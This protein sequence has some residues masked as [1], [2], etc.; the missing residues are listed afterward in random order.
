MSAKKTISIFTLA[1]VDVAAV[2][3][4]RNFPSMAVYGWQLVFWY[5]LGTIM[6]LVPVSLVAAELATGWPKEGGIYAWV[7]EAFGEKVGF[8]SIWSVFAQ[9]QVWYPT[10]L[11]FIAITFAYAVNPS[12]QNNKVY[13]LIM[14]LAI[15]WGAT[16]FNFLGSR[17]SAS[18]SSI[19]TIL[20]SIIPALLL[21]VLGLAFLASGQPSNLP[22]FS[23]Q[24]FIPTFNLQTLVFVSSIPL[25]FAGME[26]AGYQ[27]NNID[28]P[29]TKFPRSIFTAALVI[30]LASVFGT[31]PI[32]MAVPVNQLS[33]NGG[34]MQT[35]Q[36][37][38]STFGLSWALPIVAILVGIGGIAL[39]S[40]W[41]LGPILGMIPIGRHGNLPPLFR[42]L[43]GNGSPTQILVVQGF[44]GSAIAVAMVLIPSMNTAYWIL[45]ALTT[46]L[47]CVEYIPMFAAA[48]YLRKSQPDTPRAY[49]VP[50][51]NG[52]MYVV[53]GV[54]LASIVFTFLVGMLPPSDMNIPVYVY[55]PFMI[56]GTFILAGIPFVFMHFRKPGWKEPDTAAPQPAQ[57]VQEGA[58]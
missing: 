42:R 36:V 3:S 24:A 37:M 55:T 41:M 17:A 11:S 20:G 50:G 53:A 49:K 35:F 7:T 48:I 28:N 38:L 57:P 27:A 34:I 6:F 43:N 52:G 47:I 9:N 4:V 40:T 16:L 13:L 46:L 21:I 29:Q 1:M 5:L 45:S 56:L 58:Q 32:A 39:M 15:F 30:F 8:V 18:F 33:L 2:L 54:G 22:P 31:L 12:L 44:I 51:G 14:M 10:V 23:L 19:G 25:M 26:M